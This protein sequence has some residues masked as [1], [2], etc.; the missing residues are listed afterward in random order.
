MPTPVLH[1]VAGPNGAGKTT[2]VQFYLEPVTHLPFVNADVIAA[3]RWPGAEL[4]HAY[5][6]SKAAAGE[7]SLLMHDRRS[8]ITET[9]F[10]H[11]S[12]V[13][14][15]A[16]ATRLGYLVHLHVILIARDTTAAR[17]RLRV[18][19]GGHDVPLTKVLERYDRLWALVAQAQGTADRSTYYDNS[20]TGAP[21][22][23]VAEFERGRPTRKPDWPAW[24]PSDL[25]G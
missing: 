3:E 22:R 7:R 20:H 2:F 10:S 12:K 16:R 23:V 8:F 5:D 13:D 1:L 19:A 6:A 14:L 21:F 4:E 9:V 18:A 24:T 11:S 17:V 25:L 15:V